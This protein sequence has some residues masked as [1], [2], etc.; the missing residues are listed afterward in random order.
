MSQL[1]RVNSRDVCLNIINASMTRHKYLMNQ[2][3]RKQ[4]VETNSIPRNYALRRRL[5]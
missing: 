1:D 3:K 2:V 5:P 4:L